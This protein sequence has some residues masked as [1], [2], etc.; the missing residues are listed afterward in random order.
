[1]GI[2]RHIG[3]VAILISSTLC[4]TA[5]PLPPP[6]ADPFDA[7]R[8][9]ISRHKYDEA[10]KRFEELAKNGEC[11]GAVCEANLAIALWKAQQ[12]E[13]ALE[14]AQKAVDKI[15]DQPLLRAWEANEIGVMLFRAPKRTVRQLNASAKAFRF[16]QAHYTRR[17][18]NIAFNLVQTLRA[19]GEHAEA[20]AIQRELDARFLVDSS[21][22][23]L[24]DFQGVGVERR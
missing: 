1:M 14:Q 2:A 15:A 21:F 4:V 20:N 23:I 5:Q 3:T 19:L 12:P 22:A 6:P 7:E 8:T 10:I 16:A 13:R 17:G 11:R 24:G 18:S 9:L